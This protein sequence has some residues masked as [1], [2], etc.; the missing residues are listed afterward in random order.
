MIGAIF[1]QPTS[2][3][4]RAQ[5]K[6]QETTY[7]FDFKPQQKVTIMKK[8]DNTSELK[9]KDKT[10]QLDKNTLQKKILIIATFLRND[11]TVKTLNLGSKPFACWA[12][13]KDTSSKDSNHY[14]STIVYIKKDKPEYVEFFLAKIEEFM[15]TQELNKLTIQVPKYAFLTLTGLEGKGFVQP[16]K[17][18]FDGQSFI[19]YKNID[20]TNKRKPAQENE[21]LQTKHSKVS[22]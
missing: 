2:I 15:A 8:D 3:N 7:I 22:V 9:Y 13:K 1:M 16:E 11:C 12:Y 10:W 21:E 19:L 5:V 17:A 4:N 20:R 18:A 6:A 14:I